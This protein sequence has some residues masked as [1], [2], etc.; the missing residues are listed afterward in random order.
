MVYL[1]PDSAFLVEAA[2]RL[3]PGGERAAD[4][5]TGFLAALLTRRYRTVVATDIVR[6]AA[7][8]AR[9]TLALNPV[10][11]GHA[12]SALVADAAGGLRTGAFD[13]VTAN[14]PWVPSPQSSTKPARRFADGGP[15]GA[16]LPSRFLRAGAGLL[17]PGGTLVALTLDVEMSH[18]DRPLR[19]TGAALEA[20][21]HTVVM[22]PTPLNRLRPDMVQ[23][24]RAAQAAVTG[25]EH[26]AVVVA[27]PLADGSPRGAMVVAADALRR[28]WA[29]A[30]KFP[31]P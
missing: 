18:V 13:L 17:R 23:S 16:E 20:E 5:G 15:T 6:R 1:G 19:R 28:R 7:V 10:P 30:G 21:G 27:R 9:L 11:A 4:L 3:G 24:I 12:T 14:T 25:A 26:V 2:L 29:A 8:A 31:P 22:I